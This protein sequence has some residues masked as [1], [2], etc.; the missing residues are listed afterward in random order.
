MEDVLSMPEDS[1]VGEELR[2]EEGEEEDEKDEA[3]VDGRGDSF[4][5]R[6]FNSSSL[7][8]LLLP[9]AS[10]STSLP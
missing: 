10:S 5:F 4:C 9:F 6:Q 2:E 8:L 1:E 7:L 3:E